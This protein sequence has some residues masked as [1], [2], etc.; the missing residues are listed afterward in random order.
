MSGER[1]DD[2]LVARSC[3][4]GQAAIVS[5]ANR[6]ACR[7]RDDDS[8]RGCDYRC[9]CAN[10]D[11]CLGCSDDVSNNI[12]CRGLV[13]VVF[14]RDDVSNH[15]G[16]H[17]LVLT[18][19]L[20]DGLLNLTELPVRAVIV[21]E[22]GAVAADV[23]RRMRVDEWMQGMVCAQWYRV[24]LVVR[25]VVVEVDLVYVYVGVG[26]DVVVVVCVVV[27]SLDAAVV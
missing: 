7:V 24:L 22:V 21:D 15:L 5:S 23:V 13:L 10:C 3:C 1:A 9:G 27:A 14:F 17:D 26:I 12:G 20:R 6:D 8:N 18:V 19:V 11:V 16:C 2:L 25:D 4:V